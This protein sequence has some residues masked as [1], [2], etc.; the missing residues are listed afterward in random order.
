MADITGQKKKWQEKG[1][2]MMRQKGKKNFSYLHR[3]LD[4]DPTRVVCRLLPLPL[5]LLL[6]SLV[7]LVNHLLGIVKVQMRLF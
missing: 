5:L 2:K 1:Q 6:I 3:H 7:G 4:E